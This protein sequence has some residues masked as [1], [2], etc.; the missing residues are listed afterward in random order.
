MVKVNVK[1]RIRFSAA[2]PASEPGRGRPEDS[3]EQETVREPFMASA[4]DLA[5]VSPSPVPL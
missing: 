5:M 4:R 2:F 1:V 3:G